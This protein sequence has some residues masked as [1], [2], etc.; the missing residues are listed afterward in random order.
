MSNQVF[1]P[2]TYAPVF[3]SIQGEAQSFVTQI[4]LDFDSNAQDVMTIM[5]QWSGVSLGASKIDFTL[6]AVVPYAPTD[7]QGTGLGVK[8]ST[9]A[10]V[11]LINTMITTINQNGS[12]PV[13]FVFGIGGLGG[14]GLPNTQCLAQGFIKKA[15]MTYST[16]GVPMIVYTGTCQLNS[17]Q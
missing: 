4:D 8:G 17:F 11:E 14:N 15:S 10:G 16:S 2:Q 6:H 3:C 7:A 9:A 13:T 12:T 5:R 1:T